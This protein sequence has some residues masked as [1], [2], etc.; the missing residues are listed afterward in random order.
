MKQTTKIPQVRRNVTR[1]E[2][3]MGNEEK[4][5][6][7]MH[8][9]EDKILELM[10]RVKQKSKKPN[11]RALRANIGPLKAN[12]KF[13]AE[14]P[15]TL[16]RLDVPPIT[17]MS[18][19]PRITKGLLGDVQVGMDTGATF[20]SAL[21]L[22]HPW[23]SA[24]FNGIAEG[25][26]RYPDPFTLARTSIF[27]TRLSITASPSYMGSA[28]NSLFVYGVLKGSGVKTFSVNAPNNAVFSDPMHW[29]EYNVSTNPSGLNWYTTTAAVSSMLSRPNGMVL[30]IKPLLRGIEHSVTICAFP[31]APTTSSL[32]AQ[33]AGWP[34]LTSDMAMGITPAQASWG[35]R[36]WTYNNLDEGVKLVTLPLD[37]RSLDFNLATSERSTYTAASATAWCGWV[38]WIFGM[39]ALDM[40]SLTCNTVEEVY[41]IGS[42]ATQY[43]YPA[44][45]RKAD[46][47]IAQA[48]TNEAVS[49][50]SQ[51]LAAT[52]WTT[53]L[54]NTVKKVG[55]VAASALLRESGLIGGIDYVGADKFWRSG[56]S[57]SLEALNR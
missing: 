46:T 28:D 35:G 52:K 57:Y 21:N 56:D 18:I 11:K 53:V 47:A 12:G 5:Q 39:T 50:A 25:D 41:N 6:M 27:Q 55:S 33:P 22:K 48:S 34:A 16:G 9:A 54:W 32:A 43:A 19:T 38:Y 10:A 45:I 31:I 42:T 36:M 29:D 13:K 20:T 14:V 30:T 26:C 23:T 37:A 40:V 2:G 7:R 49:N 3:L 24:V 15:A 44:N 4:Y 17:C 1:I 8:Q 51:G